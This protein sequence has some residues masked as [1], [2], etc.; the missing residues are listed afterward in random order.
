L[1]FSV[2]NAFVS[3]K[4]AEL[5]W[6]SSDMEK[7]RLRMKFSRISYVFDVKCSL[8]LVFCLFGGLI[9]RAWNVLDT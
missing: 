4:F 9:N 1:K 2:L 6:D 5:S 8:F 7:Q 3:W